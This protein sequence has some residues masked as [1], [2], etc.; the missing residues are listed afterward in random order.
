[1]QT[2][3]LRRWHTGNNEERMTSLAGF[4][5]PL[6]LSCQAELSQW[7]ASYS[8]VRVRGGKAPTTSNKTAESEFYRYQ[9]R[10]YIAAIFY[11]IVLGIIRQPGNCDKSP[12]CVFL[13][14]HI[15]MYGDLGENISGGGK[16]GIRKKPVTMTNFR[17]QD[18]SLKSTAL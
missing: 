2:L 5:P 10:L 15:I 14:P 11:L 9:L 18:L 12:L 17:E 3:S 1:M 16:K 8:L 6:Y 13:T 4:S 7:P